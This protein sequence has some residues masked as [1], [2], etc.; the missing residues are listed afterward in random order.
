MTLTVLLDRM[1]VRFR[2]LFSGSGHAAGRSIFGR[3]LLDAAF[4]KLL[5]SGESFHAFSLLTSSRSAIRRR[6]IALATLAFDTIDSRRRTNSSSSLR[7]SPTSLTVPV[8]LS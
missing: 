7:Q 5:S 6:L 8:S 4:Q 3:A 2:I 1:L